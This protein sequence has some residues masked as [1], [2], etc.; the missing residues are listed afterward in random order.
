MFYLKEENGV[1]HKGSFIVLPTKPEPTE[2]TTDNR[3]NDYGWEW[4][5]TP[6]QEYLEWK[7]T[8]EIEEEL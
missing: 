7:E 2:L 4:H 3:E 5:D 6:P 8:Q 1:W